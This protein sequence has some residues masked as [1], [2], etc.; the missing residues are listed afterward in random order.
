M[1]L[2][3]PL[4][5]LLLPTGALP[6]SSL[7]TAGLPCIN[8]APETG[9]QTK[10]C[11]VSSLA[12]AVWWGPTD[13]DIGNKWKKQMWREKKITALHFHR[14]V[15]SP[16]YINMHLCLSDKLLGPEMA[17]I[18]NDRYSWKIEGKSQVCV[19]VCLC[20]YIQYIQCLGGDVCMCQMSVWGL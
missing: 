15:L 12:T 16:T 18:M 4:A 10:S 5:S 9:C 17:T 7:L 14:Y 1:C 20:M 8:A 11:F 19:H 6:L 13:Y 3:V 2:S